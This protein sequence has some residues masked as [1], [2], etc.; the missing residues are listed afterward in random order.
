VLP[1]GPW[2]RPHRLA[3][4]SSDVAM[5]SST[6]DLASLLRWA[7]SL[8]HV[9]WLRLCLPERRAL[10][11]PRVP[12]LRTSHPCRGGL[13]R[14]HVAPAS[15]PREESS[16]AVTYPTTPSGLRTTGIK[17]GPVAPGTQLDS[18]VSKAWLCVT[19]VPARRADRPLQFSSTVQH[20][21]S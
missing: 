18:L 10:T 8:P 21:S 12:Q 11:L 4:L 14:C 7:P 15:P 13:R 19:K 1:R 2:P 5:R 3:E 16:G 17:K 20:M 6:S 9:L